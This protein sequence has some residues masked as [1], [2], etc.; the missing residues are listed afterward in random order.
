MRGREGDNGVRH[1]QGSRL[2]EVATSAESQNRN[3]GDLG[4]PASRRSVEARE[5]HGA[6]V[7]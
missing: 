1:S 5:L 2:R 4:T 3:Q 7:T 6:G